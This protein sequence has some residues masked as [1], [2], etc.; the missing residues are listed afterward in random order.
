[1]ETNE[2]RLLEI[3]YIKPMGQFH[4]REIGRQAGLDTKTVM[5]YLH[6]FAKK[7]III[8][9]KEKNGFPFY[10]ANRHS[11][12][13]RY[14]KTH[15]VLEKLYDLGLIEHLEKELNPKAI[16]LFGSVRKGTYHE[17]SDIDL[18]VQAKKKKVEL[19]SFE[20]KL[21]HKIS[22]FFDENPNQLSKG[23]LQNIYN[24]IV[25]VGELEL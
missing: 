4:V 20:N 2:S 6:I 13:Y 16:I 9:R 18:F 8:R 17:N 3:F 11:A 14:E 7:G 5:K 1:M 23:L 15:A 21:K 25:L 12:M 22:L 24:G 10:E 19:A